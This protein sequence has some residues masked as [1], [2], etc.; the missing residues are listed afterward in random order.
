MP[1]LSPADPADILRLGLHGIALSRFCGL[2]SGLK[3]A[4]N[5][6]DGVA[7]VDLTPHRAIPDLAIRGQEAPACDI[8]GL[9]PIVLPDNEIAGRPV[10]TG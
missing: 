2:W 6:V 10:S 8:R 1:I 7:T 5:V 3:L 9:G 4:T